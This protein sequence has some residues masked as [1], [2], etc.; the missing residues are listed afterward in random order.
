MYRLKYWHIN[1]ALLTL[2]SQFMMSLNIRLNSSIFI[3]GN[4][5]LHAHMMVLKSR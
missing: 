4:K 1:P 3:M 5:C 2:T